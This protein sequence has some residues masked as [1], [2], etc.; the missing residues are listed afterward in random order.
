[1]FKLWL[2]L[3]SY[4]ID[5]HMDA[6]RQQVTMREEGVLIGRELQYAQQRLAEAEE[7][8]ETLKREKEEFRKSRVTT[9]GNMGTLSF[10]TEHVAGGSTSTDGIGG[11]VG[12]GYNPFKRS[13]KAAC[14]FYH[15]LIKSVKAM[16]RG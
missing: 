15:I 10:G 13:P 8:E 6:V 7:I 14:V 11:E 16:I 12:A 1:M 9:G 4:S 5:V 3:T 2:P